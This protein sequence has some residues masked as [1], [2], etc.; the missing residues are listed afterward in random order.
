MERIKNKDI[1]ITYNQYSSFTLSYLLDNKNVISKKYFECSIKE[2]FKDFKFHIR[3]NTTFYSP[4]LSEFASVTIRRLA[5]S[6]GVNMGEAIDYLVKELPK[7]INAEKVCECCKD[8]S[9]CYSCGFN[10]QNELVNMA[11]AS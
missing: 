6:L 8:K 1:K 7:N 2:A 11:I 3:K 5:W 4:K 10:N 9:K